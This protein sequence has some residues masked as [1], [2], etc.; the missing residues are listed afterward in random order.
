MLYEEAL[1]KVQADVSGPDSPKELA[2]AAGGDGAISAREEELQAGGIGRD[3]AATIGDA[4]PSTGEKDARVG[5]A[6]LKEAATDYAQT[7]QQ[8]QE[9]SDCEDRNGQQDDSMPSVE[10]TV[11]E[12]NKTVAIVGK[13]LKGKQPRVDDVKGPG[14]VKV[15]DKKRGSSLIIHQ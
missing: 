11:M 14:R 6:R 13:K 1:A 2:Q 10:R 4:G 3:D 5:D 9:G 7:G 8:P 12:K 15:K